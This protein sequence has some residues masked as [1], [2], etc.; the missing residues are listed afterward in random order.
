MRPGRAASNEHRE[1]NHK[2]NMVPD[3][4]SSISTSACVGQLK[5][6]SSEVLLHGDMHGQHF[7]DGMAREGSAIQFAPGGAWLPSINWSID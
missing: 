3:A 5:A 7:G 4:H 1:A 2:L 6:L